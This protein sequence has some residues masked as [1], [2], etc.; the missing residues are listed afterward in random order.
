MLKPT[1][2]ILRQSTSM[3]KCDTKDLPPRTKTVL[4]KKL[5]RY[6]GFSIFQSKVDKDPLLIQGCPMKLKKVTQDA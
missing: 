5:L 4:I 2:T 1:I 3:I 6:T